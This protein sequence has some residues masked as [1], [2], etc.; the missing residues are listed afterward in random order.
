MA[1]KRLFNEKVEMS[2]IDHNSKVDTPLYLHT[3]A[4]PLSAG[5]QVLHLGLRVGDGESSS[6]R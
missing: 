3:N 4:V 6:Q 5:G 1:V 2:E